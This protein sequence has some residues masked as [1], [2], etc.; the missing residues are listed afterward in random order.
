MRKI[1]QVPAFL[2]A[3]GA[4]VW[5]VSVALPAHAAMVPPGGVLNFT[6]LRDGD[7]VGTHEI[8]FHRNG[9]ALEVDIKTRIAVKMAFITVFRF[10]HDGHEVWR[11]N[12]LV[13]METKTNDDGDDHQLV[14][15]ADGNGELKVV[16]DGTERTV[17]GGVIPASLWNSGFLQ[18]NELLNSLVGTELAVNVAFKG[19]EP[20][21]VNGR[22][23]PAKHYSMT[24][25]FERELWYDNDQVLVKIAFKAK[26]GSDIQ[27]VLR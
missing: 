4:A 3:L 8:D 20:V 22:P 10:E 21:D 27:Y 19:E 24:G 16:G 11:D 23:V 1:G 2:A 26:D 9:D 25:E 15:T 13:S 14:A 7:D 6:V 18:S 12:K 17:D 5:T